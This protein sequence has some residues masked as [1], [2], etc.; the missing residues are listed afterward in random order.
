[1]YLTL[2]DYR[3]ESVN[4]LTKMTRDYYEAGSDTESS[5]RRNEAAYKRLFFGYDD[6]NDLVFVV[7][8]RLLVIPRCL[9]DVSQIDCRTEWLNTVVKIPIGVAPS[10]FQKMAHPQGEIA[11]IRGASQ[12]GALM[13]LSSWST[14]AVGEVTNEASRYGGHVWFQVNT[15][16]Y[17]YIIE[18][19]FFFF[20]FEKSIKFSC[21][22]TEIEKSR[23]IYS[24]RQKRLE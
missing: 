18:F 12:A 2:D 1:M 14:T 10:A 5:L 20:F 22:S 23:S 7:H 4:R 21:M 8:V 9:R 13:I 19:V 15:H 6:W 17:I 16:I 11:T 24:S 3:K